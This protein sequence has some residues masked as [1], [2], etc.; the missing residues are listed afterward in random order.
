ME[1][2]R[3]AAPKANLES[4]LSFQ[5]SPPLWN[6]EAAACWSLVFTPILGS[7]L[8]MMNWTS[9]GETA[10]AATAKIWLFVLIVAIVGVSASGPL[11]R[12]VPLIALSKV[13]SFVL[14]MIWYFAEARP[15]ARL[16][17]SRYGRDYQRRGWT[18]PL[19]M[20]LVAFIVYSGLMGVVA[21]VSHL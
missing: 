21:G 11:L 20:S 5:E 17:K 1:S 3:Y 16:V 13:V 15:Q 4:P 19:L 2:N 7:A 8:V 10:R 9:M 12:S 14:L 6:P 18:Q